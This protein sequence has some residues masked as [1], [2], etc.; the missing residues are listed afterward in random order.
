MK[1]QKARKGRQLGKHLI[2]LRKPGSKR[3]HG[4]LR[5]IEIC[6]HLSPTANPIEGIIPQRSMPIA[7]ILLNTALLEDRH[8]GSVAKSSQ[9]NSVG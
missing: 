2:I 6:I 7:H 8:F 5:V 9:R 1:M 3:S 4:S